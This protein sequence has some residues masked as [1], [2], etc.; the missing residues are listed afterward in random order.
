MNLQWAIDQVDLAQRI[1]ERIQFDKTCK[2]QELDDL[3]K[4]RE[5]ALEKCTKL[6]EK[7]ATVMAISESEVY[8]SKFSE[9]GWFASG[10][11][12]AISILLA[13]WFLSRI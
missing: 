3:S 5:E 11:F 9:G 12:F 6:E 7:L 10:F 8:K 13:L 4:E 2:I 1:Q